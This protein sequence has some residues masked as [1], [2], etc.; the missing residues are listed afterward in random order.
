MAGDVEGQYD[1]LFSRVQ[2]IN[3]KSGPF[4]MLFCVGDF[5]SHDESLLEDYKISE[6]KGK[7][8]YS[9]YFFLNIFLFSTIIMSLVPIP[10]FIL[11]PSKQEHARFLT[12]LK[13][14][15]ICPNL[16]YLGM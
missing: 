13:G 1:A 3:K 7:L 4:D 16:T 12:D 2:T 15:E 5:F 9:N 8:F 10:T 11:G 6:K 14:C